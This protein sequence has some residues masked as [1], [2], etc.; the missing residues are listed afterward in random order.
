MD[1]IVIIC[2]FEFIILAIGVLLNGIGIYALIEYLK[3]SNQA[4]IL[5][6]LCVLEAASMFTG[7]STDIIHVRS[8][9][10]DQHHQDKYLNDFVHERYPKE[11][12]HVY[13]LLFMTFIGDLILTM[14]LLVSDRLLS[15]L[16]PIR[17]RIY[18]RTSILINIMIATFSFSI[19]NGALLSFMQGIAF[20][21]FYEFVILFGVIGVMSFTTYIVIGVMLLKTSKRQHGKENTINL[22]DN[23]VFREHRMIRYL[24]VITYMVS[25]AIPARMLF[26]YVKYILPESTRLILLEGVKLIYMFAFV[27]DPIVYIFLTKAIRHKFMK[28]C[29][30]LWNKRRADVVEFLMTKVT[31]REI[32]NRTTE[33]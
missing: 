32:E 16:Y 22:G 20:I 30:V 27:C 33:L 2:L 7:L 17:Y 14:A 12:N 19:I 18:I 13:N 8:Y 9:F 3:I 11:L 4:L 6:K 24:I 23:I 15:L 10:N 31:Q 28:K 25:Y 26:L 29:S 5:C 21:F 1:E